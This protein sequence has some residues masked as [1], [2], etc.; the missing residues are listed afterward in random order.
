ML[1]VCCPCITLR[2]CVLSVHVVRWQRGGCA[3]RVGWSGKQQAHAVKKNAAN[4]LSLALCNAMELGYGLG[5]V[6]V[7]FSN[8][9]S[10][11]V[12]TFRLK[13]PYCL[14]SPA[15]LCALLLL[16]PLLLISDV[17]ALIL[18]HL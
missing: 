4:A 11:F 9:P 17:T 13:S 16:A 10:L 8:R 7:R 5:P 3:A 6:F 18:A 2:A 12:V 1:A 15:C 14:P